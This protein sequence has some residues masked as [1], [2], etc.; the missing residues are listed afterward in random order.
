MTIKLS[1]SKYVSG[2]NCP[3]AI[4]LKAH[5]KELAAETD[6][7]TERKFQVGHKV[8]ELAHKLFPGGTLI[9]EDHTK[10][11]D[12]VKKT[13]EVAKAGA[14]AIFEAGVDFDNVV[15]RADILKRVGE[16]LWDLYEVKSS[17]SLKDQHIPDVAVQKYCLE[18]AGYPIRKAYLTHLNRNYVRRGELEPQKLFVHE[19]VTEMI[20][21]AL[22]VVDER[23]DRTL[24]CSPA[25][26][27]ISA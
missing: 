18:G 27:L 23:A 25:W 12:A 5:K 21:E 3:K 13:A 17:N 26:T 22:A 19:D 20:N 14:L 9:G 10:I 7:A 15:C 2:L 8:G 11:K 16:N 1:K 4:W 6:A 24:Y